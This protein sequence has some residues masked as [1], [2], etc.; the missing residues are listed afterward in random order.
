MMALMVLLLLLRMMMM[1]RMPPAIAGVM[2]CTVSS[3]NADTKFAVLLTF[4]ECVG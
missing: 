1:M 4:A 2:F 3:Q